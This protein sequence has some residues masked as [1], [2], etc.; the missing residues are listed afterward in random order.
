MNYRV[1]EFTGQ[2]KDPRRKQ[3]QRFPL[4]PLL[5]IILMGILS[6]SQSIKGLA[7]FAKSNEEELT[8]QLKLKHGVPKFNALRDFLNHLDASLLAI[9]FM[10]WVKSYHPD[11]DDEFISFDGKAVKS[12]VSG[13]NTSL[14]NFVAVVSAFGHKS[15]MVYGMEGYENGKSAET[16]CVRDLIEK[17][18]LNDKVITL[19]ALHT[20]KKLLISS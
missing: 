4:E 7:R 6:G 5:I 13:G 18:G 3:G 15:G 16:Q 19:D 20:K 14:Q 17:L 8:E 12:T 2:I 11:W 10:S 9:C 1:L